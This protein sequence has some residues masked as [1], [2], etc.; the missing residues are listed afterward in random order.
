M[1]QLMPQWI[2]RNTHEFDLPCAKRTYLTTSTNLSK[3]GWV[4]WVVERM[5]KIIEPIDNGLSSVSSLW[6]QDLDVHQECQ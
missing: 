2:F 5:N 3:S 4:D 1:L 6:W